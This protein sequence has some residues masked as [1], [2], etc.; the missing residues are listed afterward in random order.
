MRALGVIAIIA[1]VA[2]YLKFGTLSPCGM[3]RENVRQHDGLAAVLPDSFV[4]AF[5]AAQYGPLSPGRCLSLL[6]NNQS[7]PTAA[8]PALQQP[9]PQQQATQTQQN[10]PVALAAAMKETEIAI[11]EC[12][13]KRI[14]G[15]IKTFVESS[16]CSNPRIIQAFSAA[17]YRYMDLIALFTAK[18]LQISERVDRHELTEIQAQLENTKIFTEIVDAERR[19]DQAAAQ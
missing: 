10:G 1:I 14:N 15:E 11:N 3:L 18:R 19:R 8:V 5:T 17:H 2:L 16:K 6:V 4:D 9:R 7:S 13:A 12:R